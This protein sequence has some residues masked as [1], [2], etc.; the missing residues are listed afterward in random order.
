M[1]QGSLLLIAPETMKVVSWEGLRIPKSVAFEQLWCWCSSACRASPAVHPSAQPGSQPPLQKVFSENHGGLQAATHRARLFFKPMV[2]TVW[3]LQRPDWDFP[4]FEL[5]VRG[6]ARAAVWLSYSLLQL[7]HCLYKNTAMIK[8]CRENL[9]KAACSTSAGSEVL[10]NNPVHEKCETAATAAF[11]PAAACSTDCPYRETDFPWKSPRHLLL[12]P[13]T[14]SLQFYN[15]FCKSLE[16][17]QTI[18]LR[19]KQR[20]L[21]VWTPLRY[22]SWQIRLIAHTSLAIGS[23]FCYSTSPP[24]KTLHSA[25]VFS[26]VKPVHWNH[27]QNRGISFA[28]KVVQRTTSKPM[29]FQCPTLELCFAFSKHLEKF[30]VTAQFVN[31]DYSKKIALYRGIQSKGLIANKAPVRNLP[32]TKTA[33]VEQSSALQLHE[34]FEIMFCCPC[35]HGQSPNKSDPNVDIE[36][37]HML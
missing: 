3:I 18:A 8:A 12:L 11:N 17:F 28:R 10:L 4:S 2:F 19:A 27:F 31:W 15:S 22:S 37:L 26:Y 7:C 1:L 9:E 36:V 13:V 5:S 30:A 25:S 29:V 16:D 32:A 35:T 6:G 23:I 24:L 34:Y 33:D 14:C 20:F 21:W